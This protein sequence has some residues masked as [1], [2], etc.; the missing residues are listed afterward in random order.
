MEP[1]LYFMSTSPRD[2]ATPRVRLDPGVSP[3]KFPAKV[4]PP[5]LLYFTVEPGAQPGH[6]VCIS[7]PHGP[8][9]VPLPAG[10]GAGERCGLRLGPPVTCRLKVPEGA[11]PG[12]RLLFQRPGPDP[13]GRSS[14][15]LEATVPKGCGPGDVFEVVP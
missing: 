11:T 7:G 13:G 2:V 6:P 5:Q 8:L 1:E 3:R 4:A 15:S 10:V 9:W 14:R 12:Q